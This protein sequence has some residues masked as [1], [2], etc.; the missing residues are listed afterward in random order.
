[1]PTLS[2]HSS[3]QSTS[4]CG[5]AALQPSRIPRISCTYSTGISGSIR[6]ESWCNRPSR[7]SPRVL[8][9]VSLWKW[10]STNSK[11]TFRLNSWH[12]REI[13]GSAIKPRR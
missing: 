8:A 6:S 1:M 9:T 10:T 4:V 11:M 7:N 2:T 12:I 3:R 13:S 5:F